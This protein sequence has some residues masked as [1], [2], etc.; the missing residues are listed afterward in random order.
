MRKC[1]ILLKEKWLKI[2]RI[3]ED[4]KKKHFR[5]LRGAYESNFFIVASSG[6]LIMLL[7]CITLWEFQRSSLTNQPLSH[8]A[9]WPNES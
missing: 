6:N 3:T 8:F 1:Y 2:E 4:S 7:M 5:I 9:T